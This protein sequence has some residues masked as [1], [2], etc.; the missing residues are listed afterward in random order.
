MKINTD[1]TVR[2]LLKLIIVVLACSTTV[3]GQQTSKDDVVAVIDAFHAALVAGDSSA[4]LNYLAEDVTILEGGGIENKEHYRSGHLAG[5]IR[6]AQAVPRKRS[7]MEVNIVGNIA[8]T[9]STSIIQGKMGDRE[10]NSR[11]AE[12][13]VLALENGTW[14]IKAIHW[15]SRRM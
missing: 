15:S 5:D 8:W 2:T 9:Y 12:L 13:M 10:I 11:G 1:Q 4:A 7:E 6:F 3:L 14:K